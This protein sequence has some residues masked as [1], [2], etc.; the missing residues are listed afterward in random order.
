MYYK[1]EGVPQD[2]SQAVYWYRKAVEQGDASAQYNLGVMYYKGEGVP[3]DTKQAVYWWQ[4]AAVQGQGK[5]IE[6]LRMLKGR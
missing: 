1:G 5:A 6:V 4:K 2:S 3:Q